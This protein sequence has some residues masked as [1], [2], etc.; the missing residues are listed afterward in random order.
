VAI[1]WDSDETGSKSGRTTLSHLRPDG[2]AVMSHVLE[3]IR[4][5]DR[6]RGRLDEAVQE[7]RRVGFAVVEN[8]EP[9]EAPDGE[10]WATAHAM[11][12]MDLLTAAE[13][14]LRSVSDRGSALRSSV[15]GHLLTLGALTDL[16]DGPQAL[17]TALGGA[18]RHLFEAARSDATLIP[19]LDELHAHMS[20]LAIPMRQALRGAGPDDLK[21]ARYAYGEVLD[22]VGGHYLSWR[23]TRG[24]R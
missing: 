13:L 15:R 6:H 18:L 4:D 5:R 17:Q 3:A 14:S 22:K 12:T 23:L 11:V 19:F 24:R 20:A 10:P 8:P 9:A 1:A 7:L 21:L 16:Q 2:G